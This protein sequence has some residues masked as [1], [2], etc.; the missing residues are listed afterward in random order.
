MEEEEKEEEEEKTV[1]PEPAAKPRKE[2][3]KSKRY[4]LY[5]VEDEKVKRLKKSCPRCGPGIFM[6]DHG[7]RLACGK[8]GYTEFKST[9]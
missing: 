6:A 4:E 2:R 3:D 9:S 7:E 8:C 5:E 1:T